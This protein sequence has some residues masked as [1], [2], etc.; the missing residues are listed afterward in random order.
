MRHPRER[1]FKSN[2]P[3]FNSII[4]FMAEGVIHEVCVGLMTYEYNELPIETLLALVPVAKRFA[5]E[6]RKYDAA[7]NAQAA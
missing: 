1:A 4:G 2:D 6:R 3:D 5:R 7:K